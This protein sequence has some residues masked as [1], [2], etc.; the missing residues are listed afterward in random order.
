MKRE[1]RKPSKREKQQKEPDL[2]ALCR[3]LRADRKP[4][5]GWIEWGKNVRRKGV[6]AA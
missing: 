5:G 4:V 1:K 6:L 3:L 2:Y